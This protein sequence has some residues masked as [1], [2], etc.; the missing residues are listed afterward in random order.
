MKIKVIPQ[1]TMNASGQI[2]R[3]W[4]ISVN[5][6]PLLSVDSPEEAEHIVNQIKRG[7]KVNVN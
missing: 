7:D 6:H 1:T 2:I 4:G 5:G 3:T